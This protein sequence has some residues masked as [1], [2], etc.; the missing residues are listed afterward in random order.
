MTP[1][2]TM[3]QMWEKKFL[4]WDESFY[5]ELKIDIT[6]IIAITATPFHVWELKKGRREHEGILTDPS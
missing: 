4:Q 6:F 5:G 3:I 2:R 1:F